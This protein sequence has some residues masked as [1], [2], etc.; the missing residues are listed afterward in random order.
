MALENKFIRDIGPALH[1]KI[2]DYM[3][4]LSDIQLGNSIG[5]GFFADVYEA[6]LIS[7]ESHVAAK[8]K[9]G[10]IIIHPGYLVFNIAIIPSFLQFL[11]SYCYVNRLIA[12]FFIN[13]LEWNILLP[14]MSR[15]NGSSF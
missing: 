9:K 11:L 3:I 12:S 4:P 13:E 14:I 7:T 10:K 8:R 6:T 1:E 15:K 2:K 5:S